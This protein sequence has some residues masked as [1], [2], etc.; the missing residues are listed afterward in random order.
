MTKR[1]LRILHTMSSLQG[2]GME[3]FVVRLADAQ[4]R[5]GHEASILALQ[6]GPLFEQAQRLGIPVQVLGG[7]RTLPRLLRGALRAALAHPDVVHAHNPTSV[8]YGVLFKL[9]SASRLV[10]TDHRGILRVPTTFE[11]LLT[12]AVIAV[13]RDTGRRS[14]AASSI[15]V[16]VIY[17][18]VTPVPARR[19]RTEV[20]AELNL[21][22]QPVALHV[23]NYLPV[24]AHDVLV[25][26]VAL[27]RDRGVPF[28]LIAAGQGPELGRIEELCRA[29]RLGDD[30]VRLLGYRSDVPDLLGAADLFVLPSRM[31]GV[32]LAVLEAMSHRLPIVTTRVGGLPEIVAEGEQ[33]FLVP[34]EDEGALAEALGKLALDPALRRR[35]GESGQARSLSEFSFEAMTDRYDALYARLVGR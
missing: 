35:M 7:A 8:H 1:A 6:G 28:T 11:W 31:E 12:D 34:P 24:K 30:R 4:R 22:D 23:G 21:G 18:G 33:G 17:N 10:V 5:R 14:T 9:M 13:S 32:P 26:A 25:K 3:H 29:L 16:Q 15:D 19:T 2:G 20:R 27:L